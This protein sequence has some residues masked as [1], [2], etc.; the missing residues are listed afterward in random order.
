MAT[1]LKQPLLEIEARIEKLRL[2]L[3]EHDSCLTQAQIFK[4][5][6][7]PRSSELNVPSEMTLSEI[8]TI[9]GETELSAE[10]K[11]YD[12]LIDVYLDFYSPPDDMKF[13]DGLVKKSTKI[14]RKYPG[15]VS[16]MCESTTEN[17]SFRAALKHLVDSINAAKQEFDDLVKSLSNDSNQRFEELHRQIPDLIYYAVTRKITLLPVDTDR[18]YFN[19][20]WPVVSTVKSA[21]DLLEDIDR[22]LKK[23]LDNPMLTPLEK[24]DFERIA[25]ADKVVIESHV[26]TKCTIHRH[27]EFP[28]PI[29]TYKTTV[30]DIGSD[31]LKRESKKTTCS[32]P[33]LCTTAL[34]SVSPLKPT[35]GEQHERKKKSTRTLSSS[36]DDSKKSDYYARS[37]NVTVKRII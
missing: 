12:G 37:L 24:A 34:K 11:W 3:K 8:M 31:K 30:R 17:N 5:T 6:D 13:P 33:M 21:T 26:S 18:V 2:F 32:L 29:I 28:V 1:N 16:V 4:V 25:L 27:S 9:T 22:R 23:M 10:H 19:W 7:L 14:T 35:D 20:Q 36:L 15:I